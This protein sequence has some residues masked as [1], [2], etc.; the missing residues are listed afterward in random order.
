MKKL[1]VS[2]CLLMSLAV[3]SVYALDLDSTLGSKRTETIQR[4]VA[5]LGSANASDIVQL[6]T[7]NAVLYTDSQGEVSARAFFNSFLPKLAKSN[8]VLGSVYQSPSLKDQYLAHFQL[9]YVMKD[10]TSGGG[11]FADRFV[12]QKGTDKLRRVDM[13]ERLG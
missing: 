12:F 9:I 11:A 5:D 13:Y 2:L 6:F 7:S 8:T 1:F 3:S 10:G 4:Y